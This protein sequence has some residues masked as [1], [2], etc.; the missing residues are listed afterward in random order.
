MPRLSGGRIQLR[1]FNLSDA[2]FI[3]EL[4]NSKGWIDHIGD[5]NVHSL[6]DAKTFI[7]ESLL[8]HFT[9]HH[10]GL[11]AIELKEDKSLVGMCG[12]LHREY[13][14]VPDLGFALHE[15]FYGKGYA[16]EAAELSIKFAYNRLHL[17]KIKA[18][19]NPE[20][21]KSQHLLKKI[22]FKRTINILI[23]D[24]LTY[25]FILDLE[26]ERHI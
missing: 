20:N 14:D 25:T 24:K 5:R 19:T 6:K 4:L 3:L 23:E 16:T 21:T 22:G 12:L 11:W 13:L 10:F 18:I 1:K 15:D 26:D 8:Q 9:T 2:P 7:K 17:R